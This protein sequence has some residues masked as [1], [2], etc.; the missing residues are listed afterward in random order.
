MLEKLTFH[1]RKC[2][3]EVSYAKRS[4]HLHYRKQPDPVVQMEKQ[5]FIALSPNGF[6]YLLSQNIQD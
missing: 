5:Y 1:C 4:E 2:Q 6:F 3:N